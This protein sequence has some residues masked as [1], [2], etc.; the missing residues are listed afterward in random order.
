[1]SPKNFNNHLGLPFS[2]LNTQSTDRFCV[3]EMGMNH[4]G[5]ITR[6]NFIARPHI[7]GVVNVGK[8]HIG[9]F[10]D[11]ICGVAKAKEEIY[12]SAPQKALLV[13]NL[14]NPWTQKMTRNYK[15]DRS[16]CFSRQN[17][18]ADV[19]LKMIQETQDAFT[20]EGH[21][22]GVKGQAEVSFWGQHNLENLTTAITMAFGA[23]I[24]GKDLW[25]ILKEPREKASM[26]FPMIW[27][28]NQWLD[29][30][31]GGRLLFDGYNANP[32]S[33]K[34]LLQNLKRTWDRQKQYIAFFGEMLELGDL[35]P[36]EHQKLGERTGELPWSHCFFI[37]PSGNSFEQGWKNSKNKIKPIILNSY[38]QFLDLPTPFVLSQKTQVIV[39][40]SRGSALE[41]LVEFMKPINFSKE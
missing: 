18:S 11:G 23:G 13:F 1:M 28:R 22:G 21:I 32:D 15:K 20:I 40:G 10:A 38:K 2:L 31:S 5:E 16:L 37:G 3:L 7:V 12:Q 33:F 4:P 14:D 27:G 29:L 17:P 35:S 39:K 6:L 8:A 36:T 19:F 26:S 9:N 34:S 24:K 41:K 25:Q 30:K